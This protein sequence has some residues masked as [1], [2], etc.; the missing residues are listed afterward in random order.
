MTD[1]K[2]TL[3]KWL[4]A[5][6]LEKHLAV[7]RENEVDLDVVAD[8][9][10]DDLKELGFPLGDRK[11]F[12]AAAARLSA[13]PNERSSPEPEPGTKGE[14]RLLTVMFCD[15]AG[16]TQLAANLDPEDMGEVVAMCRSAAASAVE[17]HGGTIA[18]F[19]G[20]GVLAYF[21]YPQ[22]SEHDAESA[23]RAGLEAT[24]AIAG[25][26]MPKATAVAARVGIAT[27]EVVVGEQIGLPESA[28][29]LA[30]GTTPN[31]AARLQSVA[32]PSE[33]VV[34]AETQ[35]H[36]G[37]MFEYR[38]LGALTLRNI[39]TPVEAF[40][41]LGELTAVTRFEARQTKGLT[42]LIGREE[43]ADL[44]LRRWTSAKSGAGRVVLLSGEAGI[45]KSRLVQWLLDTLEGEHHASMR[46]FGSPHHTRSSLKPAIS[47]LEA[48]AGFERGD[49][50]AVELE[51]LETLLRRDE[52]VTDTDIALLAD[53]LSVRTDGRFPA[54]DA[55]AHQKREMT[56]AC[57]IDQTR[58]VAERKPTVL[59]VEDAH[60]MDP[61]S[62]DLLDRL[63]ELAPNWPLLMVVTAR[64]P[65]TL[66]W[67]GA[68]HVRSVDLS[69]LGGAEVVQLVARVAAQPVSAEVCD[70]IN[71]RADG[72][73]LFVEEV[74]NALLESGSLGEEAGALVLGGGL[75]ELAIPSTLRATLVARLDR[76]G[77]ARGV[78]QIG[79]AVGRD[80]AFDMIAAL[81]PTR[82]DAL[83][84]ALIRLL[85]AGLLTRRGA[86]P[87]AV[88]SFKH[89]LVQDAAYST[90][91][92]RQRRELHAR[93]A[94]LLVERYPDLAQEQPEAVAHHYTHADMPL[95]A[96]HHWRRAGQLA[97]ERSAMKEAEGLYRQSLEM[98]AL[99]EK[100]PETLA[101]AVDVRLEMRMV[102]AMLGEVRD[103]LT[104]LQVAD[105]IADALGDRGRL[106]VVNGIL[107]NGHSLVGDL[108]TAVTFAD[109]AIAI[110]NATDDVGLKFMT[111]TYLENTRYLRG[112]YE[113][114][115][116]LAEAN[117]A[118]LPENQV[119]EYIGLPIPSPIYDRA[120]RVLSLAHLGRFDEAEVPAR[121]GMALAERS[122]RPIAKSVAHFANS[123]LRLLRGDW[124]GALP[125][126]EG[127]VSVDRRS[128]IVL[129]LPWSVTTL[130]WVRAE[131]GL[132][133]E[134][135]RSE[136]EALLQAHEE[137]GVVG[138]ICWAYVA[139]SRAALAEGDHHAARRLAARA[140]QSSPNHKGFHAYAVHLWADIAARPE[141][142]NEAEAR[143]HYE[144][145][146][147]KSR[148]LNMAPLEA[149]SL[150]GIANLDEA[151]GYPKRAAP[152]RAAAQGIC[153][154]IGMRL[155]TDSPA[156]ELSV[157][158]RI[159]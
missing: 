78:A 84:A 6:G 96:F 118:A 65:F 26:N 94:A 121:E 109:R 69:R 75:P 157:G 41:V 64:P 74:T 123:T 30:I 148:A 17:R 137:R 95:K 138:Y 12:L 147:A 63:V 116:R 83:E 20:D 35:R 85:D 104:V 81:V 141:V 114:V 18:Q 143:S 34:A 61:T 53:L 72:I 100:T 51:K 149:L 106:G 159:V 115:A 91:L 5:V 22:A 39:E 28:E 48:A 150:N 111:T 122:P 9:D 77:D 97:Y 40:V 145:A 56:L 144:E 71:A 142:A 119:D 125:F 132:D 10:G 86:I 154:E 156:S 67:V 32:A 21:G 105:T 58:R 134:A 151:F 117:L 19:L 38:E 112:E 2:H 14:R 136:G 42:P 27:G 62:L 73:P 54:L 59:I 130:A 43:E 129:H 135:L 25:L 57:L 60:W 140:L 146:L 153:Q 76:L 102:Y 152:A 92:H 79:A 24:V 15:I 155:D 82:Q 89:A 29:R 110:A 55:D 113:E 99:V 139:L 1:D 3:E 127:W 23:I 93:I 8:L 70:L 131:A 98:L 13:S 103:A 44:L 133:A 37:R 7:L 45:G 124:Q 16:S 107:A 87:A 4:T 68:P 88:F 128:H 33:V 66:P 36:V 126:A 90:L 52:G 120:W 49:S 50:S 158:T 101:N 80:F 31:L 11:R 47:Q 46:L 108:D